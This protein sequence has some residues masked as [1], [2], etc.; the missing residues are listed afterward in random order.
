MFLG[1]YGLA[2]AAARVAPRT[3][4]GTLIFA[5]Q[6]LDLLW[7][8][9]LLLGLEQVRIVPGLMAMS[10]LDFVSYP[11]S[12]S[13][14]T[15]LGWA[16]LIGGAAFLLV[17]DRRA[18]GVLG[19]LVASHWLLDAPMHRPDLPLWPG[20][21][22]L[23]GGGLWNSVAATW[24]L[25]AGLFAMGI[26]LYVRG[27]RARDRT[28][29]WA[30]W[31]MLALLVVSFVGAGAPPPS[32]RVLALVTLT[33]WLFVPWGAWISRHREPATPAPHPDPLPEV[34]HADPAA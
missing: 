7:P 5:A 21:S 26:A 16:A 12:H 19:A 28:G 15:T 34:P 22:R 20:A 33:L 1:H 18:A 31:A 14:V 3:S 30:L 8:V 11:I 2:L 4:L 29:R 9:L 32:E 6:F 13:L 23:V 27:T 17:R 24:A 10:D 25:E